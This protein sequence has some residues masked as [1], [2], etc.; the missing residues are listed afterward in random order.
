MYSTICDELTDDCGNGKGKPNGVKPKIINGR[1]MW[2]KKVN[3]D[4]SC[5][6]INPN[7]QLEILN[8]INK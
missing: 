7:A 4:P 2:F 5:K 6:E 3:F 1:K 8:Q